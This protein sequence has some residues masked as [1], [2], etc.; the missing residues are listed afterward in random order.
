MKLRVITVTNQ[1]GGVGKS[2]SVVNIAAG[3][4]KHGRRVL[5]VDTDPQA[6]A[7]FALLGPDTPRLT[8]YD[9]LIAKTASLPEVI[10][11]T[12]SAGVDLIPSHINL[13]AADIVL[14][15]VP[16]REK[17]LSRRLKTITQYDYILLDTPPSLSLLT[18]NS[19]TSASEIFIPVGVGTFGLLGI[20]LL[21][22]TITELK[23]NLE[24]DDL[25]IT[26]V[27]ATLHDRTR[28]ANDT[29]EALRSHFG[30]V[31]FQTV[32]PKSK[33]IEEANSRSMSIFDYAPNSI[34]GQAYTALVQEVMS[35]E[36]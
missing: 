5:V 14:G 3:L 17:L 11:S 29:L 2:S 7:T 25:A 36:C 12:R 24:L 27:I 18:V 33:D 6:N 13:S 1:K 9:A 35:R 23:E 30:H 22:N 31:L 10:V 21:E 26:G 4:A 19:L 15:G 16:G 34:G 32:V 20:A 28:V 8:L